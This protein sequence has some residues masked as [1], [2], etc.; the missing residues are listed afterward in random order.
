[1]ETFWEYIYFYQA[2][3]Q[4]RWRH[5]QPWEYG[6]ILSAVGAIGWWLMRFKKR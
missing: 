1:M 2:Y 3:S 6:V 5:L 4:D